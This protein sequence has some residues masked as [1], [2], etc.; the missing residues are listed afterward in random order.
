[1]SVRVVVSIALLVGLVS[2]RPAVA[3]PASPTASFGG[4]GGLFMPLGDF[5]DDARA[6]GAWEFWMAFQ[7]RTS[8]P[9]GV[10][11]SAQ[12]VEYAWSDTTYRLPGLEI[13]TRSAAQLMWITAGPQW[14]QPVGDGDLIVHAGAG[15]ARAATRS[16]V[17]ASSSPG[18]TN[19]EDT[20]LALEAGAALHWPLT[21]S[22]RL[23]FESGVRWLHTG[24]L[25]HAV[26]GTFAR[27]AT[28]LVLGTRESALDAL[29]LRA[30]LTLAFRNAGT[31]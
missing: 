16:Y 28:D 12:F 6:H 21:R 25:V 8:L 20:A 2:V 22:G 4:G 26:Q 24:S 19:L 30:G 11:V 23:G 14:A 15:V 17:Q 18:S 27:T 1:M 31:R 3:R 5:A 9:L 29:E 13:D 7:P 10:R